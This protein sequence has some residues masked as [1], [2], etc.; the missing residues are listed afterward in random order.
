MNGNNR[1][2]TVLLLCSAIL[3]AVFFTVT[4]DS[5]EYSGIYGNT[6]RFHVLANSDSEEDQKLKLAVKDAVILHISEEMNQCKTKAEAE[7]FIVENKT[8]IEDVAKAVITAHGA[9][10]TVNLTLTRE[11]YPRRTYGDVTL[12][13]GEYSSVRILLG[14]AEGQNW[15][16]VLFPQV[17][18]DTATPAEER[19]SQAGFTS[20][21]I[22]LLTGEEK[23]TYK[24]KFKIVELLSSFV[25]G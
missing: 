24:I 7:K 5:R 22:R 11:Y 23:P 12:P 3:L 2:F 15:W 18:T 14:E 10:H 13:A 9:E 16:C 25:N 21:Q 17:C 4:A 8:E 1:R 6:L 20:A 19:L